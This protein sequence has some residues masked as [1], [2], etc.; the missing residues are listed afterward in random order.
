MVPW[1]E[2]MMTSGSVG[3]GVHG[4]RISAEGVEAVA[5]GEPDVEQDDVV[6]RRRGGG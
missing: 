5:V 3:G 6:D 1:P 4:W 2:M